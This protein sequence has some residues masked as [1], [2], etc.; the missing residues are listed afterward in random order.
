MG[1]AA[2]CLALGAGAFGCSGAGTPRRTLVS[3]HGGPQV[4][5]LVLD[6]GARSTELFVDGMRMTRSCRRAGRMMRC[7]V[8]GLSRRMHRLD[9]KM[10]GRPVVRCVTDGREVVKC[11]RGCRKPPSEHK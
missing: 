3:S 7:H 1:L 4:L 11:C 5:D 6:V 9:I 2:L 10:D 8:T